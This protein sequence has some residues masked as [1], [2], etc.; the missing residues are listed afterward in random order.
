MKKV[1]APFNITIEDEFSE[2]RECEKLYE[3]VYAAKARL[4]ERLNSDDDSD[5][6]EIVDCMSSIAR[7]LSLK[8]FDYGREA[9]NA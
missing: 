4:A 6:E 3:R 9:A 1:D 5:V 7:I 2:G 8:M